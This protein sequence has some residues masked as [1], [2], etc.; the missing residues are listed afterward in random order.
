[1]QGVNIFWRFQIL[2]LV[3]AQQN[4]NV[5][6]NL[7]EVIISLKSNLQVHFILFS[8]FFAQAEFIP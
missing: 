1:M 3:L 8:H 6:N 5:L 2:I 7:Y 4:R